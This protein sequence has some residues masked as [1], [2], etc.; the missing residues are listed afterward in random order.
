MHEIAISRAPP[1]QAV[2]R[3]LQNVFEN[4]LKSDTCRW[5]GPGFNEYWDSDIWRL[6]SKLGSW[7]Y[8]REDAEAKNI[9]AK[10]PENTTNRVYAPGI[11]YVRQLGTAA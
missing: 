7:P 4:P 1:S 5:T 2:S 11:L 9:R 6:K 3:K 8:S 10:H